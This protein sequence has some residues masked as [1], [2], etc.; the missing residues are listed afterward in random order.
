MT[1][2][3]TLSD[4]KEAK[5]ITSTTKDGKLQAIITQASALVENY[6]ARTFIDNASSP[7]ITEWFD[8]NQ[9]LVYLK[10]YPLIQVNS[11]S[12]SAD[13]GITQTALTQDDPDYLGYYVDL[14]EGAV[15]TQ[16][17][18]VKFQASYN[19]PYR[20]LEINY[21]AGYADRDALPADLKLAIMDIVYYI[22]SNQEKPTQTL[23]G[24]TLENPLPYLANSFPPHIRRVLDLHRYS[25]G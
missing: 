25:P 7:G 21:F 3:I 19:T 6:C 9:E 13:G 15:R 5:N 24:A 8:S 17:T 18:G 1:D 23:M 4:Y 22:D 11:V 20:S 2:L 16:R 14:E 12:I 10:Q